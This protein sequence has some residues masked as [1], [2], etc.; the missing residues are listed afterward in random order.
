MLC[1]F[2]VES[3][4]ANARSDSIFQDSARAEPVLHLSR[5][6]AS[7]FGDEEL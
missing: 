7:D 4:V 1:G 3:L 6:V 2:Q 5:E